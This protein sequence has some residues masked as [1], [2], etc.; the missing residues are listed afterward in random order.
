MKARAFALLCAWCCA[1]S[2][3]A[4]DEVI[5]DPELAGNSPS[6]VN[7]E[8]VIQDPEL[9]APTKAPARDF[10]WGPVAEVLPPK[11][12]PPEEDEVVPLAN[13]GLAKLGLLAQFSAA[14]AGVPDGPAR[15]ARLRVALEAVLHEYDDR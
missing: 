8:E 3:S 12:P 2:A 11:V 9:G 14:A 1:Q 5:V 13:T 7:D 4:Q 6:E 10:G 15:E